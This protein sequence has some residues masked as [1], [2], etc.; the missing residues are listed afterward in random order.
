MCLDSSTPSFLSLEIP[1]T[2]PVPPPTDLSDFIIPVP[3]IGLH[4]LQTYPPT[5]TED[6]SAANHFLKLCAHQTAPALLNL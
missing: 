5:V 2:P 4:T 3:V 1:P 6:S